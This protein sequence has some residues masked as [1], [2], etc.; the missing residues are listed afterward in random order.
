MGHIYV[1]L[2][3]RV[4]LGLS[5]ENWV[6]PLDAGDAGGAVVVCNFDNPFCLSLKTPHMGPQHEYIQ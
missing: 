3:H 4:H 5:L 6:S 2:P 1:S